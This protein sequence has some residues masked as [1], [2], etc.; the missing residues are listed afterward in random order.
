MADGTD[1]TPSELEGDLNLVCNK[2]WQ[3]DDNRLKKGVD[4]AINVGVS[5]ALVDM[6]GF[7]CV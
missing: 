6:I 3:L 5:S 4:Y 1:P 7:F 2:L